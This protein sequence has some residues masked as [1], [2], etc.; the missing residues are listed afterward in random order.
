MRRWRR[1]GSRDDDVNDIDLIPL[2]ALSVSVS[3]PHSVSS[4]LVSSPF[5]SVVSSLCVAILVM[6]SHPLMISL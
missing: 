2:C 4:L 6:M 1:R 3:L 5:V